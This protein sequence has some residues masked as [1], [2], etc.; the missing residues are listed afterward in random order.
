MTGFFVYP[1][2][3]LFY[4]YILKSQ[5]TGRFYIG[6]STDLVKR[7]ENHNKGTTRSTKSGRPWVL[8]YY[9]QF[10][11][12][13]AALKREK[14]IKSWKSHRLVEEL[15]G[16]TQEVVPTSREASSGPQKPVT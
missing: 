12:R 16:T 2:V 1:G 8:Y 9:E 4:M 15:A 3:I 7:I 13:S 10:T 14:E 6:F 11:S 5:K